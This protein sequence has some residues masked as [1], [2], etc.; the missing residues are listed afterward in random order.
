MSFQVRTERRPNS[1]GLDETI[2]LLWTAATGSGAEVWPALGFNCYRWQAAWQGQVLDLLYADPR[3]FAGARATRSGIPILFPFPNRI[4]EGRF[5]WQGQSFELPRNDPAQAN[6]IHGFAPFQ[7][8]RVVDYGA[9]AASA[10]VTGEFQGSADPPERCDCWPADYRLRITHRLTDRGLRLEAVVVNPDRVP[11]PFGL[12]YHPYFRLPFLPGRSEQDYWVDCAAG[13]LWP[14]ENNLPTGAPVPVPPA[15]DLRKGR[16]CAGLGL[17]DL[18]TSLE[19]SPDR[20]GLCRRAGL[21]QASD[22]VGLEVWTS[23]AFREMVLFTPPHRQ[24][25]CLEPYTCATDALN[26]QARGL[27]AGLIVLEPGAQWQGVVEWRAPVVGG[28]GV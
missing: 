7:P 21:R 4:R 13:Q 1:M 24:A 12:G 22:G 25:I 19:G 11:L 17:D 14:L 5:S 15:Q 20:T 28:A 2:F 18:Y 8:W 9:D 27:D 26:L 6:A 16:W 10:W 23:P 3:M